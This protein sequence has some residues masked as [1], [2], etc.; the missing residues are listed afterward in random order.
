LALRGDI[1]KAIQDVEKE[2]NFRHSQ[3]MDFSAKDMDEHVQKIADRFPDTAAKDEF[4]RALATHVAKKEKS[5]SRDPSNVHKA[6][7]KWFGKDNVSVWGTVTH[8]A[9]IQEAI[10]STRCGQMKSM[11]EDM[12]A[13]LQLARSIAEGG[14]DSS[15]E[16]KA[17]D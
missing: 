7:H 13:S 12:D 3:Y 5:K 11:Q 8:G 9:R 16:E 1:A 15:D 17:V 6:G 2:F 14:I 4:Y 10:Q